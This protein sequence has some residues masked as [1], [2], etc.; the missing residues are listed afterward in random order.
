MND[1]L[2]A[3]ALIIARQE[4]KM[5]ADAQTIATLRAELE[6]CR[7]AAKDSEQKATHP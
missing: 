3:L 6:Q 7:E 1:A 2:A 4:L 5:Q